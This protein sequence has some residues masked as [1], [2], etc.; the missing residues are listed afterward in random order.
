ME[1]WQA[2]GGLGAGRSATV[3]ILALLTILLAFGCAPE[4]PPRPPSGKVIVAVGDIA[5]CSGTADEATARLVG[6]IDA[7]TVLT[8][9]DEAYP[10]GT[11][12]EFDECYKPTWGRFIDRTKPVPGNH[13]YHTG[14]A[15]GY[16]G[17]FG[18]AAGES[19]K[20]YYSYDLGEW[21]IVALN[22]NCEEV[23]CGASSPQVRWLEADLAKD[24]KS[25]T[26]AYFHY[27]LFSSGKY[28]PG[29]HEVKPLW[30]VLYA[31]DADMVLNGHD[32]N[33]QRFAP[34][35][36]NG[37]ADPQRGIREFV[38]GTGGRSHYPI[39]FPI[40]N[41][42]VYNDETYGVLTLTPHPKGYEWRFLPVEGETFTDSGS[43]KCH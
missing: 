41:S 39:L 22:S 33:Y 15:K 7:S 37:K 42:E 28:R 16:F 35:D 1:S 2:L 32:H 30:E 36:P 27:P 38:V 18:K 19:G 26:L 43:A 24:A 34:Q 14:G 6:G 13:E 17:Y 8:L 11:A 21:H 9:G 40:A 10:E 31:A 20:G 4:R 12:E 5:S 25:C 3:I 29:V 23:G